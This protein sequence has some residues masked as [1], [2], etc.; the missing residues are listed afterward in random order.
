MNDFWWFQAAAPACTELE[1]IMLD[2]MGKIKSAL[3]SNVL[4]F[5]LFTI[6]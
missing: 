1:T 3:L 5:D 4:I 6:E 2:W